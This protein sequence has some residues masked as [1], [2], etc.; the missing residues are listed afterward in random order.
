[1]SPS[2]TETSNGSSVS[3]SNQEPT[4]GGVKLSA[5][6]YVPAVTFFDR[7]GE[8]DVATVRKHAIRL[9]EAGITGIVTQGS[10]GEAV[11]LD[12]NERILIN[13]TVRS[14]IDSIGRS[15]V[16]LIVGCGAQ[17]TRETI[18]LCKEAAQSGGQFALILP[19]SYYA[20]LVS[21]DEVL[22]YFTDV[23]D[24]SPIPIMIYNYPGVAS[25]LD[26]NSDAILT[27][28]KH[29][30]IVGTKLTCANTGKMAR[31][32]AGVQEGFTTLG[33]S[34]DFTLQTLIVNGQGVIP[35]LGNVAPKSC[36][37]VYQLY[38]AGKIAEAQKAQ[39]IVA[40]G[41]WVAI[42]G[43]HIAVKC[44]LEAYFGYG[45]APR[46]PCMVPSKATVEKIV[47]DLAELMEFEKSL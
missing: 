4:S 24:A 45:G 43:G 29:K 36:I 47:A 34:A 21:P 20:A 38:K 46:K 10:N 33:G 14:A 41:D 2:L 42:K 23:A 27:L 18:L 16:P 6:V 11:L 15:D 17:S 39:A 13:K 31:I 19:P 25:G 22:Q 8:V 12:H 37:K 32:T 3:P 7:S 28:S 9:I 1:M 26:L 5:G 44:A 30:N 35:G 40:K